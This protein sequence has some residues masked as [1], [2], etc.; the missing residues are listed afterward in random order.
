MIAS[1]FL[2]RS[3][4]IEEARSILPGAVF[5]H[6]AEQGDLWLLSIKIML[7]LLD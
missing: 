1:I 4:P 6:P 3:M 7:R 5:H 2:G